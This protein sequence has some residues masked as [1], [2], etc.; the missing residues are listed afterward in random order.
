MQK[1]G[2]WKIGGKTGL[3]VPLPCQSCKKPATKR[4]AFEDLYEKLIVSLCDECAEKDYLELLLQ[5]RFSWPVKS[6]S[7]NQEGKK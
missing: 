2:W 5:G 1:T 7:E 6:E 4:V 3:K